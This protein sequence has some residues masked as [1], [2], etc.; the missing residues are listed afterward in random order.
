M[1]ENAALGICRM[2]NVELSKWPARLTAALEHFI[3][4]NRCK[5]YPYDFCP[6]LCVSLRNIHCLWLSDTSSL[7]LNWLS[8]TSGLM[9]PWLS[10]PTRN[11]TPERIFAYAT[12]LLVCKSI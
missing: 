9:L 5:K 8:V 4:E 11:S 7:M 12:I 3:V 2:H 6:N 1:C 10:V